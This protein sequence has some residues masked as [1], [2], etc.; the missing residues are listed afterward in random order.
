MDCAFGSL[1]A[2]RSWNLVSGFSRRNR[3]GDLRH[4]SV[5]ERGVATKGGA[6][7]RDSGHGC[8]SGA[9]FV[10][11]DP[12]AA[13]ITAAHHWQFLPLRTGHSRRAGETSLV[14]RQNSVMKP[15]RTQ[16]I[17]A[18]NWP[19]KACWLAVT[20]VS[21]SV[22]A[23][24]CQPNKAFFHDWIY[25]SLFLVSVLLA[26][27]LGFFLSL[28]FT[29]LVIDPL[30]N[31]RATLNGAPFRPGDR[32]RILVGPCRGQVVRV[33]DVWDSRKQVRVALDEY[34]AHEGVF[35][36]TQVCRESTFAEPERCSW[37]KI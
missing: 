14:P 28:P 20:I 22:A 30:Y 13:H 17:F 36:F 26:P 10:Q 8:R 12:F 37:K 18:R 27:I 7:L 5:A 2:F 32:I 25:T 16:Y 21:V 3:I 6:L 34:T 11:R 23:S 4:D 19:L 15:S 1:D 35:S 24:V 9:W 33:Y 31:F 29:W